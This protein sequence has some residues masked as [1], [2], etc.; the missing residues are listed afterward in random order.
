MDAK[1]KKLWVEALRSGQYEQCTGELC[2]ENRDRHCC[3][4]VLTE[5]YLEANPQ[6]DLVQR[7]LLYQ[8]GG[9]LDDQV[10]Y[11]AGLY[12]RNPEVRPKGYFGGM[13]L[14]DV[15]DAQKPFSEIADLIDAQL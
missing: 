10:C 3:L 7:E 2:N 11:W 15:N 12:K 1:V 6:P 13:R 9:I 5:L 4:G 8:T 14:S